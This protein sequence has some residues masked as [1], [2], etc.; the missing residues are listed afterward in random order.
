M[1]SR[2]LEHLRQST[3]I[4][5]GGRVLV[6]YSGG[7]DSTCLLHLLHRAGVDV[8]AAHLNHRQR[9]EAEKEADLCRAFASE[10]GIPFFAGYADVPSMA[11]E[12]KMSLEEAGRH[13]RYAF[14][15]QVA[16]GAEA[17]V[18]ATAHTK[19]DQ[20]ETVLF[21]LVRGA[22]PSGL[23]GIPARRDEVI[24]PLLPF[25]RSETRAYCDDLG[26]WYHEDPAN[27]DVSFAR[28]RIRHRVFPE[29]E[30]INQAATANIARAAAI[31]EEE[32]R[33]L[34]TMAANLLEGAEQPLNGELRFL[35][36]DAEVSF[37]RGR[38]AHFPPVLLYRA[39]RL[40]TRA[41]G[42]SLDHL[43]TL[44]VSQ[45]LALSP[46]GSVTSQE[47]AVALEWYPDV[48]HLR[49]LAPALPYRFNLTYPGETISDE[50]GW[51]FVAREIPPSG[52]APLR[53]SLEVELD[54]M[55]IK[56]GLYFRTVAEGDEMRP[57]GFGGRRKLS[58]LLSE[59]GL[60]KLAR[61]RLPIVC[62]MLG[63]L[64]APG[65]CA[66]ERTRVIDSD[67]NVLSISFEPLKAPK[68]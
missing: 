62:D 58:D 36:L 47:G 59:S 19:S 31:I 42:G 50:F 6:G 51:Q 2:F 26:L 5:T 33:F 66:D 7:A 25:Q 30:R 34:D 68:A 35:T 1:F 32:D 57:L 14:L 9:P 4:P 44:A 27:E 49:T 54:L 13:A 52:T 8:V 23:A 39:L 45:G 10:L 63:P 18:I 60:T 46:Q 64:W 38:L 17:V 65:V 12:M 20:A 28:A 67:S 37:D 15:H 22:G 56:G 21:N 41:L 29:L 48:L 40:A 24:R 61:A 53:R 3:L 11:R 43:Q 16:R 55:R